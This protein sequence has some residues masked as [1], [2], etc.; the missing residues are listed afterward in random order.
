MQILRV[1][2]VVQHIG[3]RW[4]SI[5]SLWTMYFLTF[6][7]ENTGAHLQQLNI[8]ANSLLNKRR[9]H[10]GKYVFCWV[11]PFQYRL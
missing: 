9:M 7:L 5:S 8:K 6:I 2:S 1:L 11:A 10:L 4:E 3:K